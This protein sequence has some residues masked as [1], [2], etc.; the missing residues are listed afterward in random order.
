MDFRLGR[1]HKYTR[2]N[3]SKNK[4]V[5][6]FA[7]NFPRLNSFLEVAK[8]WLAGHWTGQQVVTLASQPSP[9]S[10]NVE[11]C[12]LYP[13]ASRAPDKPSCLGLIVMLKMCVRQFTHLYGWLPTFLGVSFVGLQNCC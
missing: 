7:L 12:G 2:Q 3:E 9:T 6:H 10:F 13:R 1:E 8:S 4:I 5:F 11:V